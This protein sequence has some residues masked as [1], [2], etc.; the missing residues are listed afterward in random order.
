M[1]C[2]QAAA[3]LCNPQA[4]AAAAAPTCCRC[5]CR[6]RDSPESCPA[7]HRQAAWQTVSILLQHLGSTYSHPS[8]SRSI[9]RLSL[10]QRQGGWPKKA[11]S[12]HKQPSW[13]NSPHLQ[14][15]VL[16]G[17]AERRIIV[18]VQAR[19]GRQHVVS[20]AQGPPCSL[21]LD[22]SSSCRSGPCSSLLPLRLCRPTRLAY[23]PRKALHR[24]THPS[25]AHAPL[26]S[27]R[28][29]HE[30]VHLDGLR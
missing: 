21:G 28:R 30:A 13:P 4:R 8:S 24:P 10:Q 9:A 23:S 25:P 26:T 2:C 27:V 17:A 19:P 5:T 7:A 3:Q 20:M 15:D 16:H 29:D 1:W 22:S 18:C 6:R 11:C 12:Q 14:V